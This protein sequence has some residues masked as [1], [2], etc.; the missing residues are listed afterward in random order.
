VVKA[1]IGYTGI[2]P[3]EGKPTLALQTYG[4]AKA[5][6]AIAKREIAERYFN[7]IAACKAYFLKAT[8]DALGQLHFIRVTYPQ[9][10][11]E[12]FKSVSFELEKLADGKFRLPNIE[13]I[14]GRSQSP[15]LPRSCRLT[16]IFGL[17]MCNYSKQ[18]T[19]DI[20]RE[21]G[22]RWSK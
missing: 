14:L 6:H 11:V 7:H 8:H 17:N 2:Q 21:T 18:L 3:E 1:Q 20:Q 22:R 4:M 10:G 16:L 9:L 12:K 13:D 19:S 15:R 5:L